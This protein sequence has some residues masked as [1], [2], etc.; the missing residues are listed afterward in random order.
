[1]SDSPP[2]PAGEGPRDTTDS[3][4]AERLASLQQVWW[5]RLLPV[6][7]PYRWNL[8]RLHLG[9]TLEIGCGIG[10]NLEHL[11][12]NAVGLD[13]N[14]EAV[15]FARARGLEA[16]T[17]E[18]FAQSSY[19]APD[20]F[21]CLLLAHVVEHMTRDE[22]IELVASYLP[23]LRTGGK[24][25]L[26]APQERGFASDASHV[27]FFDLADLAELAGALQLSVRRAYS[28]PFPRAA[29]RAFVYNECVVVAEK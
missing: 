13:H 14:V 5:K 27:E 16:M 24:V 17:P 12:G 26:I 9:F 2:V 7:A 22:A 10:R 3:A 23:Y 25:V 29:G 15:E 4:Y 28:F 20:R 8:R 11:K 6:Q 18:E 21:D 1:M 19:A